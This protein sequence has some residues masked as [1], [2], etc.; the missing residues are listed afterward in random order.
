MGSEGTLGIATESTLSILRKP[1]AV[2]TLLAAFDS[3]D[4][5]GADQVMRSARL[6][7]L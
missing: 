2:R 6:K 3:T 7:V 1:E 4:E 5:A